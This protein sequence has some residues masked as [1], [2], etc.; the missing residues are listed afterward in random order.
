MREYYWPALIVSVCR[1]AAR[2]GAYR[3][4][5]PDAASLGVLLL[6]SERNVLAASDIAVSLLAECG[7]VADLSQTDY[8]I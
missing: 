8:H 1:E 2:A 3:D 4:A 5:I 7:T 6:N